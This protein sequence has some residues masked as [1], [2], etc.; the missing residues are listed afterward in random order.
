MADSKCLRFFPLRKA[1]ASGANQGIFAFFFLSDGAGN[2]PETVCAVLSELQRRLGTHSQTNRTTSR[3]SGVTGG[4]YRTGTA[5][6]VN[7]GCGSQD[8][9]KQPWKKRSHGRF[10][11][12]SRRVRQS[13]GLRKLLA[14][15]ALVGLYVLACRTQNDVGRQCRPGWCLVPVQRL[16]IIAD[17]LLVEAGLVPTGLILV[18]GPES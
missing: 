6:L 10:G 12:A 2:E 16:K 18:G 15:D 9:F 1:K 8:A 3:P 13:Q 5:G 14:G 7:R 11:P 4:L 17:K